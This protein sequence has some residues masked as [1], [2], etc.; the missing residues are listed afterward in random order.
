MEKNL[1]NRCFDRLG[2]LNNERILSEELSGYGIWQDMESLFKDQVLSN[3]NT[4]EGNRLQCQDR[5]ITEEHVHRR[6]TQEILY[7]PDGPL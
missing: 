2:L 3:R 1:F 4:T 5:A 7:A 6:D